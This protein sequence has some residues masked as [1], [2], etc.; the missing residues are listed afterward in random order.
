[1]KKSK[2]LASGSR[3]NHGAKNT[4]RDNLRLPHGLQVIQAGYKAKRNKMNNLQLKVNNS[5]LAC[6]QVR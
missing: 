2:I 5:Q 4:K 1:M 6:T 3:A